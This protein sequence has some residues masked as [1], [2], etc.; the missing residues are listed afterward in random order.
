MGQSFSHPLGERHEDRVWSSSWVGKEGMNT[1]CGPSVGLVH[2]SPVKERV[3]WPSPRPLSSFCQCCAKPLAKK[4]QRL[5][6]PALEALDL[7]G[8]S[9]HCPQVSLSVLLLG[10][11]RFCFGYF[12][13]WSHFYFLVRDYELETH[14]PR[15]IFSDSEC[16]VF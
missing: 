15:L 14:C 4:D 12:D 3:S 2:K 1:G 8:S 16:P 13:K 9:P 11:A 6:L 10:K 7:L 5:P